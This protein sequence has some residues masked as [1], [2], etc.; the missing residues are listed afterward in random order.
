MTVN[1]N[2]HPK[3]D[4]SGKPFAAPSPFFLT[5]SWRITRGM[6]YD[7]LTDGITPTLAGQDSIFAGEC[8]KGLPV[9]CGY[10]NG[11]FANLNS[12]RA[13]FPAAPYILSIT[14]NG[15]SG[16]RCIDCEPGDASVARA[17][18][19]VADNL[20]QTPPAQGRNDQGKPM[21]YCSAGDS[22]A[23]INAV[24]ALGI[25]RSQWVLFSAHWIG[26]HICSP[27]GCGFPQADAT[28]YMDGPNFDSDLFYAYCFG[29]VFPLA[30]GEAGSAVI[31]LQQNINKWIS[32]LATL[33]STPITP[34]VVD[35]EFGALTQAAVTVAQEFFGTDGPAGTASQALFNDLAAPPVPPS[36]QVFDP[37]TGLTLDGAGPHSVAFHFTESENQTGLV[38]FQVVVCKGDTL[39][40]PLFT[41]YIDF[42][43]TGT[44]SQ[45]YGGLS[46]STGYVLGVRGMEQDGSHSSKWALLHFQTAPAV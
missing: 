6:R 34:L 32:V 44:Y 1:A 4:W 11:T 14:P 43:A 26:Q 35:G 38:K 3:T 42:E 5:K 7:S 28:Q 16:A 25:S 46:P 20:P 29:T 17:A 39:T 22:K 36:A 15:A 27:A 33:I 19:F 37:V 18:Q 30:I 31:T 41:H 40:V 12:F 2:D 9:Y 24:A 23:V 21:V 45:Q 13:D 10:F 8:N